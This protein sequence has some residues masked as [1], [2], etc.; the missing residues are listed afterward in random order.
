MK[1]DNKNKF[2][3]EQVKFWIGSDASFD[4]ACKIIQE[5]ANGDY[6]PKHLTEDIR[7]V[8]GNQ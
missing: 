4:D 2:T 6:D 1:K 3:L 8:E 5:I 7:S